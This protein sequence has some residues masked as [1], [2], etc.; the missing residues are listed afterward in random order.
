MKF[1]ISAAS[2]AAS[3][4]RWANRQNNT[5]R[6]DIIRMQRAVA[7]ESIV[8]QNLSDFIVDLNQDH[9]EVK[10]SATSLGYK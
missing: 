6:A 2:L 4:N 9:R 3:Q 1:Q 8:G 7:I 10:Q 5:W